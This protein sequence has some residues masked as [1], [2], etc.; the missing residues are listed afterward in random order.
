VTSKRVARVCQHQL[1]F[2][3][4]LSGRCDELTLNVG[5]HSLIDVLAA[6]TLVVRDARLLS[7]SADRLSRCASVSTTNVAWD[8]HYRLVTVSCSIF[9]S[10]YSLIFDN[11][12]ASF[13]GYCTVELTR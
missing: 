3:F 4:L 5:R 2:S 12:D 9:V 13:F 10:E 8:R 1:S 6:C 11:I 7:T